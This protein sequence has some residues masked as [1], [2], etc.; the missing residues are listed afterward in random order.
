MSLVVRVEM[1]DDEH[2]TSGEC[3]LET[4]KGP[5]VTRGVVNQTGGDDSVL[6]THSIFVGVHLRD[7]SG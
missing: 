7:D 2:R 5:D 4:N 3:I 6:L 1:Q